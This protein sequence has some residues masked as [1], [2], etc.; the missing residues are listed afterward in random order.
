M[1][2]LG[3]KYADIDRLSSR[4]I[5]GYLPNHHTSFDYATC[6]DHGRYGGKPLYGDLD[7]LKMIAVPG[8]DLARGDAQFFAGKVHSING[9]IAL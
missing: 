8:L 9:G 4:L 5:A 3:K 6:I 7:K 2:G 1:E